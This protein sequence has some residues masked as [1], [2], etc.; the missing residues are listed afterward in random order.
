[1]TFPT[2]E[3]FIEENFKRLNSDLY[4][5]IENKIYYTFEQVEAE[6]ARMKFQRRKEK[7][8]WTK[9]ITNL[10]SST[11]KTLTMTRRQKLKNT[12]FR[13]YLKRNF[14]RIIGDYV[15]IKG[16]HVKKVGERFLKQIIEVE[17]R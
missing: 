1:M 6:Y 10:A 2:F 3:R 17:L 14:T 9:I 11:I 12:A 7:F 8:G 15:S 4:Q 13:M 5:G 16:S